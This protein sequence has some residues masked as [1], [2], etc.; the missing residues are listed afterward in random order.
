MSRKPKYT[1]VYDGTTPFVVAYSRKDWRAMLFLGVWLT[2]WTF[3][4]LAAM[5]SLWASGG[6]IGGSV[7]L[8]IWLC[9]WTLGEFIVLGKLYWMITGKMRL[10]VQH[11][12]VIYEW[13]VPGARRT[14]T[15][16]AA[17]IRNLRTIKHGLLFDAGEETQ[18]AL[19]SLDK[20]DAQA[21]I[22]WLQDQLPSTRK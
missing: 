9:G 18:R 1:I 16:A 13:G 21:V 12:E 3:G 5:G 11:S 14:K 10:G 6:D 8:G 17:D 4:G 20:E 2:F 22:D 15:F 7:F 19:Q